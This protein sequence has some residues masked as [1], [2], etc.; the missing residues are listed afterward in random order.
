MENL[1]KKKPEKTVNRVKTS[2]AVKMGRK[3]GKWYNPKGDVR[4]AKIWYILNVQRTTQY[5]E[6]NFRKWF[7]KQK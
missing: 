4:G 5:S 7:K 1:K 2:G 3:Y 6:S